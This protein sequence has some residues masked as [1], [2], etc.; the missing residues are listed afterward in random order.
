MKKERILKISVLLL[1]FILS[2]TGFNY[3]YAEKK[4][5]AASEM[6]RATLP[7]LG[8]RVGDREI[9]RMHGYVD[10]IDESLLRDSII[11]V[12][13]AESFYVDMQ[14]YDYDITAVYYQ[15]YG[16]SEEEILEEG[17]L[18][19]LKEKK[20]IKSQKL[21]I[22]TA[23]EPDREYMIRFTIRLDSSRKFLHFFFCEGS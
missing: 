8:V 17:V 11:P 2:L 4:N 3:Y 13:A 6:L 10:S 16:D 15:I 22:R 18:N 9:N 7:V 21:T 19:K 14:D 1:V 23:L 12:D 20:E 5:E